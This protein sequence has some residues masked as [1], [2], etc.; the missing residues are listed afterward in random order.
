MTKKVDHRERG[1]SRERA[2]STARAC[3]LPARDLDLM[4]QH[5]NL[6]VLGPVA[7]QALAHQP[8]TKDQVPERQEHARRPASPAAQNRTPEA[9]T[10]F[11]NG[12][13]PEVQGG[14]AA[15]VT[16]WLDVNPRMSLSEIET[17][18]GKSE[19][20]VR[21]NLPQAIGRPTKAHWRSTIAAEALCGGSVGT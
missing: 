2:D 21:R 12:T 4:T 16:Y 5:E 9:R 1:S 8:Q 20:T 19:R 13:G 11:P 15:A 18:I 17:E 14:T 6:D 3:H 7:A 10:G